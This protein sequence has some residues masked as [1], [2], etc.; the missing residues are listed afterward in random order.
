MHLNLLQI[1]P[2]P[3]PPIS[4]RT[5][6]GFG[7]TIVNQIQLVVYPSLS[8]SHWLYDVTVIFLFTYH[9]IVKLYIAMEQIF[10]M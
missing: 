10:T 5:P 2:V 7:V 3:H 6:K 1:W 8:R 4:I 9:N